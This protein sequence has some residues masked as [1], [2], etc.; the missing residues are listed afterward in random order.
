VYDAAAPQYARC[1]GFG[2]VGTNCTADSGPHNPTI[3]QG[4]AYGMGEHPLKSPSGELYIRLY[5]QASPNYVYAAEKFINPNVGTGGGITFGTV[6]WPFSASELLACPLYDCNGGHQINPLCRTRCPNNAYL[7]Q[8][9][10]ASSNVFNMTNYLG[11]WIFIEVHVKANTSGNR[12]GIYELWI[13]DCGLNGRG[14][15]GTPTLRARYNNVQWTLNGVT[16]GSLFVE[17]WANPGPGTSSSNYERYDQIIV[18]KTGPI[19]FMGVTPPT[20]PNGSPSGLLVK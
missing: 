19:G 3:L 2:A 15:T 9:V 12:D 5:Y 8:N 16:L 10:G 13:D 14:C 4:Q 17:N 1:G 11:H 7:N 18:S 20:A 6:S